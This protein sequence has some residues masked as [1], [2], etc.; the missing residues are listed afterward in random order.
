MKAKKLPSG[1]WRCRVY[2]YTDDSGKKHYRS[3]TCQDPSPK[4]KRICEAEAAAWAMNKTKLNSKKKQYLIT[5]SEAL[6]KYITDREKTLSPPSLRK[7][8]SLQ[9]NHFQ[10]INDIVLNEIDQ[11]DVQTMVNRMITEGYSPR[12]IWEITSMV[13][14][15][16]KRNNI[17]PFMNTAKPK[18]K[19][20][21]KKI[22]PTDKQVLDMLRE[23]EGKEM[24]IC[25]MLAAFCGLR[26]E[27]VAAL[28]VEDFDKKRK[29]VHI[30]NAMVDMK[31]GGWIIK[32][33]KTEDGDRE[34]K[35]PNCILD[36]LPPSGKVTELNPGKIT[37]RFQTI[38]KHCDLPEGITFHSLR[39]YKTSIM[40]ML[41]EN[42]MV[43][44]KEMGW[45]KKDFQEMIEIYGHP[46]EGHEFN[47]KTSEYFDDMTRYMTHK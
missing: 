46:V 3:F 43:V 14:T 44:R 21:K 37:H 19:R 16:Q 25:I 10:E 24:Y 35:V 20:K 29:I 13:S 42:D 31:G 45:S 34:I 41:G 17:M 23:T 4:G 26:R 5:F 7:Y 8:R 2:D 1:S 36:I 6:D 9:R 32:D 38:A 11:E 15:I 47:Q 39:H 22:V 27:E 18:K 28:K 33:T 12:S 30:H 40:L